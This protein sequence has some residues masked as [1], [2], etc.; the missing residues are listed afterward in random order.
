MVE[1]GGLENRCACKRTVGSNPTPS[2]SR[3]CAI[4]HGN[5]E[6]ASVALCDLFA[7]LRRVRVVWLSHVQRWHG[8]AQARHGVVALKVIRAAVAGVLPV[9]TN[10]QSSLLDAGTVSATLLLV[11]L[12][13]AP[14]MPQ[15]VL[16]A[17]L[18][19]TSR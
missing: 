16:P 4:P 8:R 6:A 10:V 18:P 12:D 17:L 1:S 3:Q 19:F 9:L 15:N 7:A 11:Q 5:A 13:P 2:A 14:W